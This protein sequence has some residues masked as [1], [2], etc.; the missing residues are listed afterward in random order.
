[1]VHPVYKDAT[2]SLEARVSDL[3][4]AMSLDEKLAQLGCLWSSSFVANGVFDPSEA[5]KLMPH[6]IGQVTRIGGATALQPRES[7]EFMNAIQK[8]VLE[9]TRLGIPVFVHEEA[10]AGLLQRDA[11]VFPQAL[12]L[13]STWDAPLLEQIAS[14]VRAQMLAVGARLALAPVMD[15]A[16]DPRWGRVE[17]TY[18]EDPVLAGT[19]GTAFVRGLQT[20]DLRDG[21]VACAKHF[22]GHA[23]S[24]GGRNCA[25]V[26]VGPRE[27]REVYAEPFA[28]AIRDANLGAVMPAYSSVDGAPCTADRHTLGDL[29]RGELGFDG[30]VV[31]DYW[32][33]NLLCTFHR[34]AGSPGEAARRA[35]QAGMDAELPE[36]NLFAAPLKA[37]VEA[38]RVPLST[39]DD[40]VRR[41]LRLKLQLGL[42]DRPYVDAAAAT[43]Q[44]DTPEQRVLARRAA[45]ECA[46]L[47]QNDGI[48]PLPRTARRIA[49]I[50]P[51]ADDRRLLQGD[52]HY[53]AHQEVI[54]LKQNDTASFDD[55]PAARGAY[56]PGPYY[57]PHVTPLVALRAALG[58]AAVEYSR[59]CSV[60][61][62]DRS[63]L[64]AAVD[65]AHRA[66]VAVVIVGGKSGLLR[67]ATVG[68]GNEATSL[69]LTGVQEDLVEAVA[70]TGTPCVV[71]VVSGRVHTL[72]RV[73][74]WPMRSCGWLRQARKA[75]PAWQT[76]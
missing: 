53:P 56:A 63:E 67:P 75:D 12:G 7:A 61:S 15:V 18:G 9:H 72:S 33:I 42:F 40:A 68:E 6:G 38:G 23:A 22:L 34:V 65:A 70:A 5:L 54:F 17:E 1:M 32:A 31:S 27:L 51:A 19:L 50:G 13:A 69:D 2:A 37:E 41:V 14:V 24:V 29:L 25:P 3:L 43:A 74:K 44:F 11:T 4:E 73:S 35:I 45:A 10:L 28:A 57:T 55:T 76:S 21:V 16:R 26:N 46:V 49:V 36:F 52:Y 59:G 64:A 62:D 8:T 48:L 39:V 60:M 30:L 66:D 58:D 20:D 47:L 71:V